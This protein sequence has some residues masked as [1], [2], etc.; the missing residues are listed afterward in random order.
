MN[1]GP[2]EGKGWTSINFCAVRTSPR[3]SAQEKK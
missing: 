1:P 3:A 2:D